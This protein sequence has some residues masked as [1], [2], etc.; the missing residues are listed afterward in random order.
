MSEKLVA[1]KGEIIRSGVHPGLANQDVPLW[2]D[3]SGLVFEDAAVKPAPGQRTLFA[4]LASDPVRGMLATVG[5]NSSHNAGSPAERGDPGLVWGT[6]TDLYLGHDPAQAFLVKTLLNGDAD[7]PWSIVQF[8]KNLLATNNVDQMQWYN[9]DGIVTQFQ[10]MSTVS[11]LLTT[12]RANILATLGPYVIAFNTD[13]DQTEARWCTEDNELEWIPA[14]TN[15]ARDIQMRDL[16]SDISCVVKLAES[17]IVF[18]ANEGHTFRFIGPPFF[19]GTQHLISG[20]GA[21]SKNAVAVAGRQ[22][23]GFGADGIWQ[24]DGASFRY[25]SQPSIQKYI[26]EDT[27]DQVRRKEVISWSSPDNSEVFFSYPTKTI[28]GGV[29][30]GTTVSYNFALGVWALHGIW[31]TA[32]SSGE[33]WQSPVLADTAGNIWIQDASLTITPTSVPMQHRAM[34]TLKHAPL[35]GQHG[36]GEGYYGGTSTIQTFGDSAPQGLAAVEVILTRNGIDF[37]LSAPL[38]SN[39]TFIQTK[40]L[41]L[42]EDQLVKYLDRIL[43]NLDPRLDLNSIEVEVYGSDNEDGPYTLLQ[44]VGLQ[45]NDPQYLDVPGQRFYKIRYIDRST[46]ERWRLHGFSLFGEVGGDEF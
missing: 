15:S 29:P 39:E 46:Q 14:A 41:D 36:Y 7:N 22:M 6:D 23:F 16:S 17:L 20:F 3:S 2:E 45:A 11:D 37:N 25:I 13:N 1:F 32:A 24:S 38:D 42:G 27:Y 9:G 28:P 43:T 31:R 34:I 40:A 26:Y 33:T 18:G 35:Y 10:A 44:S 19:F 30:S 12:F 21:V 8:G 5:F 4:K